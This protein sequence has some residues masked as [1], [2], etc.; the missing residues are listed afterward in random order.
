MTWKNSEID[1]LQ[2]VARMQHSMTLSFGNAMADFL[3]KKSK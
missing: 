3:S 1:L 2:N